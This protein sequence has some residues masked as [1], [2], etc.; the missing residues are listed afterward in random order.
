MLYLYKMLYFG[1]L[2][3]PDGLDSDKI[4]VI[5]S[6]EQIAIYN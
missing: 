1:A 5:K 3:R 2:C 4:K 6:S